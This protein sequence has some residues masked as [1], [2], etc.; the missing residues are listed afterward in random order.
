MAS[1]TWNASPQ[2]SKSPRPTARKVFRRKQPTAS[3][4]RKPRQPK[5]GA[6]AKLAGNGNEMI[7]EFAARH[8]L[9]V[10]RMEG[11]AVVRGRLGHLYDH[12]TGRFGV[13]FVGDADDP[14]LDN[15][16]RS[17]IRTAIRSGFVPH[18]I[19]DFEAI[20]LFDPEDSR[21]SRLAI[22]LLGV[23]RKRRPS[24]SQLAALRRGRESRRIEKN[25][26]LQAPE[27]GLKP[28]FPEQVAPHRLEAAR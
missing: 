1:I 25:P 6:D 17:R 10:V 14:R 12:G 24:A 26:W 3:E 7:R 2:S 19:C 22:K 23:R 11:E 20:L 5:N 28:P 8:R 18:L 13:V 21:L 4:R 27:T 15:I 16:L 9:R